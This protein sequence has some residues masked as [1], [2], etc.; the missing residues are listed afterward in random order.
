MA[1]R[2]AGRQKAPAEHPLAGF[3]G[4]RPCGRQF[5]VERFGALYH[6]SA[7]WR[8]DYWRRSLVPWSGVDVLLHYGKIAPGRVDRDCV[9]LR[10]ASYYVHGY[11]S[12]EAT[13]RRLRVNGFGSGRSR[14][15]IWRQA[16]P[17][18]VQVSPLA[19]AVQMSS[20]T[21]IARRSPHAQRLSG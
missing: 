16:Q 5:P 11:P 2:R 14:G 10:G 1:I 20:T 19:G 8:S 15:A 17:Q 3:A 9:L 4:R 12:E 13:K 7:N 21:R 18:F 6:G